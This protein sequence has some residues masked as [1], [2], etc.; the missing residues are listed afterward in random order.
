MNCPY[1]STSNKQCTHKSCK[2]NRG[3]KR[4]CSFKHPHNCILFEEWIDSKL[5]DI[6][7]RE[8]A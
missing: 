4:L 6:K 8:E 7:E 5:K 3:G 2:P 1:H